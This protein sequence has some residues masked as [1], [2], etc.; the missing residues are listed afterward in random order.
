M[1]KT[2]F[3]SNWIVNN[4]CFFCTILFVAV[5]YLMFP[6]KIH[7]WEPYWYASGIENL[8][9][10]T[11]IYNVFF[12]AWHPELNFNIYHPNHPLLHFTSYWVYELFQYFNLDTRAILIIQYI[13]LTFG[14]VS[15]ALTYRIAFYITRK[16]LIACLLTLLFAFN[17]LCWYYAFSGEVYIAPYT[18]MLG[19]Y[20]VL[21]LA[22]RNLKNKRNVRNLIISASLLFNAALA[23]HLISVPFG[24]VVFY[25]LFQFSKKYE[26]FSFFSNAF[27]VCTISFFSLS[28]FYIVMPLLFTN[29]NSFSAYLEA[30]QIANP[31]S[32]TY[33]HIPWDKPT[34]IENIVNIFM[35]VIY[36]INALFNA[37]IR[38]NKV[39]V[40]VYKIVMA[41]IFFWGIF[42]VFFK[43]FSRMIMGMKSIWGV[44]L[45]FRKMVN[46]YV[47]G[48]NEEELYLNSFI[49]WFLAFFFPIFYQFDFEA[50]DYWITA[51]PSF[52][53]IIFL[54]A[55]SL[56]SEK[57]LYISLVMMII[58]NFYINFT[59]DI[60][61][62][63]TA[64]ETDFCLLAAHADEIRKYDDFLFV[65]SFDDENYFD[66][67]WY[68]NYFLKKRNVGLTVSEQSNR[69]VSRIM[70]P[71]KQLSGLHKNIKEMNHLVI[72]SRPD[73]RQR[74]L[75]SY[76]EKNGLTRINEKEIRKKEDRR[77]EKLA[78]YPLGYIPDTHF[79]NDL[80]IQ[81]YERT[82]AN[83]GKL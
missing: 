5:I 37:V 3:R 19:T 62:K 14:I 10:I 66:E 18:F 55:R 1:E 2:C 6:I 54:K 56:V 46:R 20:Y 41:I 70:N 63:H 35:H 28:F 83:A 39:I 21:L 49:V 57:C 74:K 22:E 67:V 16:D 33:V 17:D 50:D 29:V 60:Y 77:Y 59:D 11:S 73:D 34:F 52:L 48:E 68:V 4:A 58:L 51:V 69:Y 45:P 78:G 81:I 7:A 8:F 30:L 53:L 47:I 72:I 40:I 76:L 80:L 82:D 25:M 26:N 71:E 9:N 32:P 75:I 24:L 44:F 43:V 65:Y 27:I 42:E 61:P 79:Y 64:R 36:K 38:T 13:N 31:A 23:F 12:D 15:I